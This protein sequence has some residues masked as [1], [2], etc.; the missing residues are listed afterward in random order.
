MGIVPATSDWLANRLDRSIRFQGVGAG[1][2]Q[3]N[4]DGTDKKPKLV[5]KNA[6]PVLVARMLDDRTQWKLPVLHAITEI[7]TMTLDGTILDK[8]GYDEDT[9]IYF[10]PGSTVFPKIKADPTPVEGKA[11][12]AEIVDLLTDFPFVDAPGYTGVSQ[13]VLLAAILT[14]PVR[15]MLPS[16]PAFAFVANEVESGKSTAAEISPALMTG[17]KIAGQTFT[18]DPDEQ[19]KGIMAHCACGSPALLYDNVDCVVTGAPLEMAL[20]SSSIEA[21]LLGANDKQVTALTNM[22]VLMTGNKLVIGGDMT[23]RVLVCWII[24]KMAL[25]DRKFRYP[26]LIEHVIANRPQLIAAVLTALRAY[27]LHGQAQTMTEIGGDRFVDWSNLIAG[28]LIWYGYADPR[29]SGDAVRAD[30]PVK[31][32]QRAVVQQW[33]KVFD[34][35]WTTAADLRSDP[36]IRQA[37]SDAINVAERNVTPHMVAGFISKMHGV[38]LALNYEIVRDDKAKR[39]HAMRWHLAWTGPDLGL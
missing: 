13:A 11:A 30:D 5:N 24:A 31:E 28:C 18:N 15:R 33:Q 16:A 26:K 17:R 10:D 22:L 35:K 4:Q 1:N 27:I 29:R 20:T 36:S 21:R 2:P 39:N 8:P 37:V 34:E 23:S 38:N 7:P 9:G 6:P 14:G 19:R 12:M 25:K 32:G 3:K